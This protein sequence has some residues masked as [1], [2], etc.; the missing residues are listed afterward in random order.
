MDAMLEKLNEIWSGLWLSHK[1]G[2]DFT[3]AR[4]LYKFRFFLKKIIDQ[5]P[6]GAKVLEC[7]SGNHQWIL[8]IKA[9]RPDLDIWG[10]DYCDQSL[11]LAK[12]YGLNYIH[13]DAR[14]IELSDNSYDL[15]YSWGLIEHMHE[16]DLMLKEQLRVS[17]KFVS[18]DVPYKYSFPIMRL[19]YHNK[20]SG[21]SSEEEML[22]DGKFFSKR[23]F[24]DL[25]ERQREHFNITYEIR[26]NYVA[27][28][29]RLDFMDRYIPDFLRSKIGHNIGALLIKN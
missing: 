7:G 4:V 12:A 18:F 13:C 15:V 26:N 11:K 23:E 10:L 2:L 17:K 20:K 22:K 1:G 3:D 16:T 9:Y 8:L 19:A 29:S 27:L 6:I 25:L 5:L 14:Q 21:M 28:P 24:K